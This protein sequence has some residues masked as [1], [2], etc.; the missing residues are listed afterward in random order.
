M[1]DPTTLTEYGVAGFAVGCIVAVARWFLVALQKKDALIG[2]IV[3]KNEEHRQRTDERHDA[4]Y[5]RLSDAIIG[6]TKEIAR[7]KD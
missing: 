3:A 6:L 7:N 4:S 2:Q 1:I 5:N